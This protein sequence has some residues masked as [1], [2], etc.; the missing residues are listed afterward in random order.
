MSPAN[1]KVFP[2]LRAR[3]PVSED[4]KKP[5]WCRIPSS[6]VLAEGLRWFVRH[7]RRAAWAHAGV[8]VIRPLSARC[9]SALFA[10]TVGLVTAGCGRVSVR[11]SVCCEGLVGGHN[12]AGAAVLDGDGRRGVLASPA[13]VDIIAWLAL[14]GALLVDEP[15]AG[16]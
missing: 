10:V 12:A 3:E 15:F 11:G 16:R 6:A 4:R 8:C 2:T 1:V 9:G 5:A 13:D 14:A 7:P